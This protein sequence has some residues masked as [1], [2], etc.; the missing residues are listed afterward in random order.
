MRPDLREIGAETSGLVLH[1]AAC[2]GLPRILHEACYERREWRFLG[3][4]TDFRTEKVSRYE[5][6]LTADIEWA[7]FEFGVRARKITILSA[8]VTKLFLRPVLAT[9]IS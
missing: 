7:F 1:Q 4:K 6:A 2:R 5:S 9:P 3:L 8:L